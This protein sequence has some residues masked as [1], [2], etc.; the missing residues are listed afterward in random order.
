MPPPSAE[1][2]RLRDALFRESARDWLERN[3][4]G[5]AWSL[6]PSRVGDVPVMARIWLNDLLGG[7]KD[8]PDPE[9]PL[10]AGGVVGVVHDLSIP[11]IVAAAKRGLFPLGHTGGPKWWSPSVRGIVFLDEFHMPKRLRRLMRQGRYT[12]TFDRDYEH[13]VSHC[14]GKRP[15]RWHLT[16]VTP[17][18]M[19]AYAD[20]FDAGLVHSFEVWNEKGEL[21]G[22]GY[23]LAVGRVFIGESLFSLEPNASKVALSVL[24]WH[25]AKWGFSFIDTKIV[26]PVTSSLGFHEIPRADYLALNQK[27]MAGPGKP[28]RWEVEAGPEIVA[29][30]RPEKAVKPGGTGGAGP[31]GAE[32]G[33]AKFSETDMTSVGA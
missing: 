10:N 29:D 32:D 3:V 7:G 8:L 9:S 4:L 23:G 18:M 2:R 24:A 15:G 1:R 6:M 27:A 25:L 12:V 30:W 13:V 26:T 5:T 11:T 17:E 28:G 14:A 16:W 33:A 21:V 22:G 31:A 19:R 20:L